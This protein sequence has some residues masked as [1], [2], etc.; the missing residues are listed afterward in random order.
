MDHIE[1][2]PL[3]GLANILGYTEVLDQQQTAGWAPGPPVH[4]GLGCRILGETMIPVADGVSLEAEIC[5]PRTAGLYPT[6]VVFSAY[7]HQLQETGAP[8]G[9]NET[10]EAA[11]FT[12]RGYNHVVVS[13]R[14]MGRSQGDSVVFFNDVDVDDHEAVI[15]WV[16]RQEWCDGNVVL[17]GTSYYAVVQPEV[18]ARQPPAL[19]GFF[20]YGTDTDYFSQIAMFGGAPQTDFLTLWMGANFTVSQEQLHLSPTVRAALGHVLDSP[21][22]KLWE[23]QVQKRMSEI[24][25]KF[26]AQT[27][28][29]KYRELLASWIYDGKTR[30]THTIPSG[31]RGRLDKIQVPFVVV[32]DVG[33]FNLHQ[34]GAYEIFERAG[35]E[36]DQK[37]LIMA[38]PEYALPVR[39][40]QLEAIA[41]FDHIVHDASNG[42]RDQPRVRYHFDGQD[43]DRYQGATTFPI[44]GAQPLRLYLTGGGTVDRDPHHMDERP[45]DPSSN[46]W[47][48]TPFGAVVPPH[49]DE[50]ANPVLT[51]RHDITR[52]TELVGPVSASLS[53][54]CNEIDSH[55]IVRVSR[56]DTD[57][58][59]HHLS[60][61]SIRPAYRE[62]DAA[63]S[64]DTEVVHTFDRPQPLRPGEPVTLRFSLTPFPAALEPGEILQV[65]VASRTDVLRS[66]TSHGFEQF[67]MMVPPY[68]SRNTIHFGPDTWIEF[69]QLD[70]PGS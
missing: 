70:A 19:A 37:W 24:Q 3:H 63:R 31:P 57:G 40:W 55:V 62:I 54:S 48:A 38:P 4:S 12:D 44:P 49:M 35:T 7:S 39:R 18:A 5:V 66:D 25:D 13:R 21:L 14:G 56:I 61:G 16:S 20:A 65:D 29:R 43:N 67:D 17:F 1:A 6:V 33:A 64:F 8:T 10:G 42:Y 30:A 52:P 69:Q 11:V 68:F 60:M 46:S 22:R 47:A 59:L 50:V 26:K 41:F 27:P 15:D 23:P 45:P 32:T 51:F 58:H 2:Q 9:T 53:F 28:D 34:F 36:E